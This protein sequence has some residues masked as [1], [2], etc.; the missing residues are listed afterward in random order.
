MTDQAVPPPAAIRRRGGP[1][2]DAI[3][4]IKPTIRDE[5]PGSPAPD[6]SKT[7]GSNPAYVKWLVEQSMLSDAN[8]ISRL[9]A[10]KSTMWQNP[11]ARPD[12]RRALS[13]ANVWFTAYPTSFMA[14]KGESFLGALGSEELW[15]TFEEIGINAVHTGPTKTAGG[16]TGWE[17]T[18]SVDGHFDRISTM[19][20]PAFGT[21]AELRK[22][23]D[24]A[25]EHA[26]SIIDDIV[27]G[28]TGKGADFRLAEMGYEDY[29][30]IYHMVEINEEDWGLLP[31]IEEGRDSANLTEAEEKCLAEKG[32]IVG[33]LQRVLLASPGVKETNWSA[34]HEVVGVDGKHRR[35]VYLHY[36]KEGQPSINWLDP[37]F[38]GMRVIIG[39]AIHALGHIGVSALRLDANGFLGVERSKAGQPAWSEGHPLST[40]A[41]HL[42]AGMTRKVGGF[43]FQELNL[44]IENIRDMGRS[45][46]DLSYDFVTRPGIQHALLTGNTDFARLSMREGQRIGVEPVTL[47]HALQNHDEL[48]YELVH[49]ASGHPD[50]EY[51]FRGRTYTGGEIAVEIR[52]ELIE[53]MSGENAPYNLIFTT[54]GIASTSTSIAAAALGIRSLENLTEADIANIRKAHLLLAMTCAWQPGAFGVSGWDLVGALPL[55]PEQIAEHLAD[56]DTRWIGRGAYDL[57]GHADGATESDAGTP[58]ARS[59]YGPITTQLEDPNSF[60]SQ[61]KHI[62]KVRNENYVQY[63]SLLEI[64][65]VAHSG[66]LVMVHRLD[67]GWIAPEDS[68]LQVTVLNFANE[69]VSATVHSEHFVPQSVAEDVVSRETVHID[70]LRSFSVELEP[71]EG[72]F[73]VIDQH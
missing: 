59:L 36:F 23:C 41:N 15:K 51:P 40:A 42:T 31:N 33:A 67:G 35:W 11:Y 46:A 43:T 60:V 68:D 13:L 54:N 69:K 16:I 37:T 63:A 30:G 71:F 27:P 49:W 53:H 44:T 12:S 25:T 26:S 39:D 1:R 17:Y 56:G 45:G 24:V 57:L 72:K 38:A 34:T 52:S 9:L 22:A 48:T 10:G 20:D 50:D 18:P 21:E 47:I 14:K 55:K 28:H 8:R 19:I 61:L 7:D 32:Y 2:E 65:E 66:M 3:K 6:G 5:R 70:D 73:F 58:V 29:P 62:I 64:P 4:I